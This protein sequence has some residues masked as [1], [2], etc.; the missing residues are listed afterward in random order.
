MRLKTERVISKYLRAF[1][2]LLFFLLKEAFPNSAFAF[3]SLNACAKSKECLALIKE[4]S[5]AA[6]SAPT[7]AGVAASTLSTTNSVGTLTASLQA[8]ADFAIVTGPTATYVAWHYWS[9]AQNERAQNRAMAR[10]CAVYPADTQ[11]CALPFTGGQMPGILY[12]VS[13]NVYYKDIPENGQSR[14]QESYSI[15]PDFEVQATGPVGKVVMEQHPEINQLYNNEGVVYANGIRIGIQP[16]GYEPGW[17]EY[18]DAKVIRA[19]GQPDTGGNLPPVSIKDWKY[20]SQA[21]REQAVA[22]LTPSDWQRLIVSMPVGRILNSGDKVNAPR[23]AIPGQEIDNPNTVGD[24][25][26]LKTV[27]GQKAIPLEPD[28]DHDDDPDS[29]DSDNDND[30]TPDTSDPKPRNPYVPTASSQPPTPP[31]DDTPEQSEG[32]KDVSK[33]RESYGDFLEKPGYEGYDRRLNVIEEKYKRA[34][35]MEDEAAVDP[36]VGIEQDRLLREADRELQQ[37]QGEIGEAWWSSLSQYERQLFNNRPQAEIDEIQRLMQQWSPGTF[38]G[39]VADSIVY[40]ANK[41]GYGDYLEYLRDASNFDKSKADRIPHEG[42]REDSTV[43]WEI[44]STRE[45]L[46]EDQNGEMRTY[47]FNE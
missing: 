41:Y 17:F 7:E 36:D 22:L 14:N 20:W 40:H 35:A 12:R 15:N 30:G 2:V 9:Q 28:F 23:I 43:R 6:V 33:V 11:L 13:A 37:L 26:R 4:S 29:S 39:G 24:D 25:R 38:T 21:K 8:A 42:F 47:G 34:A 3:T 19:D 45:F 44:R 18:R 32:E 10:Y 31:E 27:P 1:I 46:V 5:S 16:Y